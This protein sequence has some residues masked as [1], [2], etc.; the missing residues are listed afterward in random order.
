MLPRSQV[1]KGHKS[2]K[3]TNRQRSDFRCLER[4]VRIWVRYT[5]ENLILTRYVCCEMY[6]LKLVVKQIANYCPVG[7]LQMICLVSCVLAH[8]IWSIFITCNM[9]KVSNKCISHQFDFIS[10]RN[11]QQLNALNRVWNVIRIIFKNLSYSNYFLI[12]ICNFVTIGFTYSQKVLDKFSNLVKLQLFNWV[13]WI[14][15]FK[16]KL[17]SN[18][19]LFEKFMQKY[20]DKKF[21]FDL[22]VELKIWFICSK[23]ISYYFRVSAYVVMLWSNDSLI[24][25]QMQKKWS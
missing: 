19:V 14:L 20:L 15:S 6:H 24:Q 7:V 5:I 4:I 17:D 23:R 13:F 11:H 8:S 25:R 22:K 2:A 9:I 10:D 12:Y 18:I 21:T 1:R 3:V 16:L